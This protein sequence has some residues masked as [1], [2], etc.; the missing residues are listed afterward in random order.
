MS[1][2]PAGPP[3]NE[4]PMHTSRSVAIVLPKPPCAAST[5]YHCCRHRAH[6]PDLATVTSSGRLHMERGVGGEVEALGL[7]DRPP[8]HA[9]PPQGHHLHCVAVTPP[10]SP[11]LDLPPPDMDE[12]EE[13]PRPLRPP[14]LLAL[15]PE[16]MPPS[17]SWAPSNQP[18]MVGSDLPAPLAL[19]H[20]VGHRRGGT[21]L[22]PPPGRRRRLEQHEKRAPPSLFV[23]AGERRGE[24]E[25]HHRPP[26]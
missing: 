3:S 15:H 1:T 23:A 24:V 17:S 6:P 9:Q 10:S 19:P 20:A 12:G 13:Q 7:L 18:S 14:R 25:P 8:P 4:L 21:Q 2:S 26:C 5:H 16:Q 22:V 11:P